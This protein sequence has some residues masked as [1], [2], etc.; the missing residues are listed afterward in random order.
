MVYVRGGL[1]RDERNR[2]VIGGVVMMIVEGYEM[3][4]ENVE[5]WLHH[6]TDMGGWGVARVDM[7]L[8]YRL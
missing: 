2:G 6:D 4:C 3:L 1:G 8:R 7:M 5:W